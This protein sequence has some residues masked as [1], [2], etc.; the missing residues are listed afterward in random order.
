MRAPWN[1]PHRPSNGGHSF[2]SVRTIDLTIIIVSWNV[3]EALLC[4]LAC[5][6]STKDMV[7]REVIVIDNASS[8]QSAAAV[9]EQFP[10][11][12]VIENDWNAGFAAA[13]NQGLRCARGRHILL[14]NP[15]MLVREGALDRLVQCLEQNKRIGVLGGKLESHDGTVVQ[16]VRRDPGIVDQLAIALKVPH[17]FP[18]VLRRYLAG[19]LDLSRSQSVDQLRGSFFAFSRS[20]ADLVGPFDEGYYLWFEEVDFCRRVREAGLLVHFEANI[21]A[22]DAVGLSFAQVSTRR[23]QRLFMRSQ[24]YY[25]K[26]WNGWGAYL[27]FVVVTPLAI[28][29]GTFHDA[30][31]WMRNQI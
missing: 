10:E 21:C 26:K 28:I 22:E 15:D 24:R 25:F 18:S 12:R 17:I 8:D 4:N 31:R 1:R 20:V 27:L 23:K 29:A 13:V 14:L 3:R 16:S 11:A 2:H 19:D 30:A 5:L 7:V 6:F 9:R